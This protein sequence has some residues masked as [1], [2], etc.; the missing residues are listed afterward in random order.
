MKGLKSI[1]ISALVALVMTSCGGGD[2]S[3]K[4]DTISSAQLDSASYAIG[5]SFGQMLKGSG[6]D[7]VDYST[8]MK[9][10]KDYS[11]GNAKFTDEDVMNII[12]RYMG[13]LHEAQE[14]AKAKAQEEFFAKNIKEEGVQQ[15]ESG[16]Q[17]KIIEAGDTLLKPVVA[18]TV[19]VNYKGTLLDGTEF[20]SSY[21]RG[22]PAK[23]PLGNVIQG[24]QEG[25]QLVGQGGKIKLWIPFSL[26]YG[27]Q[28]MGPKLPA[29]STLVFDVELLKVSKAPVTEEAK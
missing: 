9:G 11:A 28:A 17:Y 22:E 1:I 19:E 12:N 13:S 25:I 16:L 10:L 26:G 23:F 15:T 20:D 4:Y 27:G 6:I 3:V 7:A 21:E 18:D 8:I 14:V 29:F 2:V 5:M 24:W